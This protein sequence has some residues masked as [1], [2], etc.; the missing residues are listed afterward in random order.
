MIPNDILL[1]SEIIAQPSHHQRGLIQS[2]MGAGAETHR[3][4]LGEFRNY[5]KRRGGRI[6]GTRGVGDT[7]RTQHLE[8]S[9]QGSQG[10]LETEL[11]L[12]GLCQFLCIYVMIVQLDGLVGPLTVGVGNVSL[13]FL[14]DPGPFLSCWIAS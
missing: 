3:Q 9:K 11:S 2:L 6:L 7:R 12:H 8:S 4:K 5:W 1:H 14:S 13:T 10:L